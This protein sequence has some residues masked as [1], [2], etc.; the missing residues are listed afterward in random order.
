MLIHRPN[1]PSVETSERSETNSRVFWVLSRRVTRHSVFTLSAEI[2]ENKRKA[3]LQ[4]QVRRWAPFPDAQYAVQWSGNRASVYAWNDDEVKRT[5]AESGYNEKR[6]IVCPEGFIREPQQSG[7]RLM[8]AIDGFEAQAWQDGFLAYS[9]WWPQQPSKVEWDMFLR[10]AGVPLAQTGGHVPEPSTPPF[11]DAPWNRHGGYLGVTWLLEDPR[12][13]AAVATLLAAPFIYLGVEYVTLAAAHARVSGQL[14][15]LSAATQDIRKT[16]STAIANLDEIED[17]LSLEVYPNQFEVLAS[18]LRLLAGR[19]IRIV[20]WTYD[21][22]TLSF[23]LRSSGDIDATALITAFEK[24]G[25][26]SNVTAARI[27]QEGQVRARMDVLPR[28]ASTVAQATKP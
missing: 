1:Q 19:D 10:S 27:G 6:C 18:A 15:S 9:R 11:L 2:P 25:T 4:I 16:R 23:I 22:G 5:I 21:V 17:F 7:V 13:V 8:A 20:E 14:E 3:V 28:K 26:F 12:T 24:S